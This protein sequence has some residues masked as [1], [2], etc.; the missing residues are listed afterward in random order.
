MGAP[1]QKGVRILGALFLGLAFRRNGLSVH[2]EQVI[3][4]VENA[5]AYKHE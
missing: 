2:A 5:G 1:K 3:E 4:Q